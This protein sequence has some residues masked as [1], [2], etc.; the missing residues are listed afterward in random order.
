QPGTP[1][2]LGCHPEPCPF[3]EC[4]MSVRRVR[5]APHPGVLAN[6]VE[7]DAVWSDSGWWAQPGTPCPLGCH[8]EPCP[9]AECSMSV[10]RVRPN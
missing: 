10:R 4:S 3:A 2:P 1:C 9:F 6:S 8:P 5:P 7:S